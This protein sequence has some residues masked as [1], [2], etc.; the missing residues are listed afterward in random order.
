[1]LPIRTA[2]L[3]LRAHRADDLDALLAYYADPEVAR[4]IPWEPWSRRDAEEHL[5]RRL[6]RTGIAGPGTSLALA[7]EL[8]GQLIGDV[9]MWAADDTCERGEM[10]WAFNPAFAGQ[11]YAAEAVQA[12]IDIAFGR[13]AMRRVRAQVDARNLASAARCRRV[14]MTHEAYLREDEWAKGEWTDTMIFGLLATDPD[15]PVPAGRTIT[16]VTTQGACR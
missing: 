2:R 11:G 13:Y 14:D 6:A 4:Y 1:M 3:L 10:G 7:A 5:E 15:K 8:D 16:P 12:M 9:A